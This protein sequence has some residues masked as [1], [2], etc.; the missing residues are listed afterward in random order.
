MHNLQNFPKRKISTTVTQHHFDPFTG[1]GGFRRK[2]EARKIVKIGMMTVLLGLA[3]LSLEGCG[4]SPSNG[5]EFAEFVREHKI[6]TAKDY[7][8]EM[9]NLAGEWEPV[10]FVFGYADDDG[11]RIECENAADG[12]RKINFARIYRCIP[13]N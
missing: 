8:L 9:Q 13:A 10:M 12:L 3:F 6:G 4:K 11:T 5:E 7:M 2:I 1:S